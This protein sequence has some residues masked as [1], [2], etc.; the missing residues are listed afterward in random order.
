MDEEQKAGLILHE[1]IYRE[2]ISVSHPTS[3]PTRYFNI[4]LATSVPNSDN[5][6]SVVAKM[7]LEW[8][9]YGGGLVLGLLHIVRGNWTRYQ[10]SDDLKEIYNPIIEILGDVN[11]N[12]LQIEFWSKPEIVDNRFFR[13]DS[14]KGIIVFT[15]TIMR[16]IKNIHYVEYFNFTNTSDA[17]ESYGFFSYYMGQHV[18]LP[19]SKIIPESSWIKVGSGQIVRD[20]VELRGKDLRTLNGEE[21]YYNDDYIPRRWTKKSYTFRTDKNEGVC[22]YNYIIDSYDCSHFLPD[23]ISCSVPI[24][25]TDGR[26]YKENNVEQYQASENII[27][28]NKQIHRESTGLSLRIKEGST[29]SYTRVP[30][31]NP[32]EGKFQ[33]MANILKSSESID[34]KW[35]KAKNCKL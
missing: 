1:L 17:S 22:L 29:T 6:A 19:Y 24:Y 35:D 15:F 8:V 2:A 14:N 5:Y 25:L 28:E 13:L 3:A 32:R 26:P 27:L 4:F 12:D 9:E 11:S 33:F 21:W 20:I 30:L 16:L 10:Y 31:G 7:P 23:K 18:E 34:L